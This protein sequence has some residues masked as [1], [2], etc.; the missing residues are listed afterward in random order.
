[1]SHLLLERLLWGINF[2]MI[3]EAIFMLMPLFK[4]KPF[5]SRRGC[6]VAA[7]KYL[8][9]L[10]INVLMANY[11]MAVWMLIGLFKETVGYILLRDLKEGYKI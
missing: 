7:F 5:A 10:A 9:T 2:L 11:P 3:F 6:L 4:G 8:A 1:M